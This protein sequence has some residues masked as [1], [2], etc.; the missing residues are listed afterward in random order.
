MADKSS[1]QSLVGGLGDF[2]EWVRDTLADEQARRAIVADLGGDVDNTPAAPQ[3]PPAGLQSIKTYRERSDADLEAFFSA[4]RDV[5]G[6]VDVVR[7]FAATLSLGGGATLDETVRALLDLLATNYFRLRWPWVYFLIQVANFAEDTTSVYGDG[8]DRLYGRFKKGLVGLLEAALTPTAT[9]K[10]YQLEEETGPSRLYDVLLHAISLLLIARSIIAE[11]EDL[12]FIY[13]WDVVP[14][15]V[16]PFPSIDASLARMLSVRTQTRSGDTNASTQ[17]TGLLMS[18]GTVPKSQGGPALYFAFGGDYSA[19]VPLS[20]PWS[21]LFETSGASGVGVMF[22]GPGGLQLQSP[23]GAGNFRVGVA[24]EAQPDS[25]SGHSHVISLARG[26][27]LQ[28]GR[29]RLEATLDAKAGVLQASLRDSALLL[30]ADKL[31]GF[32][33]RLLPPGGLRVPFDL[34]AGLSSVRGAFIEGEV[35]LLGKLDSQTRSTPARPLAARSA[36]RAGAPPQ[37]P[38]QQPP[39]PSPLPPAL[40]PLPNPAPDA[41]GLR[42]RIPIGRSIG[43]VTV[44]ELNF[45]LLRDGPSEDRRHTAEVTTSLSVKI[46]PVMARVEHIGLQLA[47]GTPEDPSKANSGLLDL[48][49][50]LRT[51]DGVAIAIDAKGVVSGG[52]FL[53]HDRVQGLYAGVLQ[54]SLKERLTLTAFGLLATRLPDGS[55][56]YSLLV[57]ITAEGF[58]PLP[59]GLGF[60]LSAIGGMLGIHRRFDEVAMREGLKSGALGKLLFPRDVV[61]NAAEIIRNLATLFPAQQGTHLV[62]LLARIAWPT[63]MLVLMELALIYEINGRGRLIVLGRISSLLPSQSND[64]VRLNLDALGLLDFNQGTLE[65]DAQLVDSRLAHQFVLT[66]AM[67]LRMRFGAGPGAGFAMAVGGFNPRFSPPLPMPPLDRVTIALTTG[68]NP[69][70]TCEA[71]IAITP[72]TVQFGARASLYAAAYGFSVEGDIGF[73]VLIQLL[74]FHFLADFHA[75]IQLKHGTHNLFKVSVKG[76]LEGPLPLRV[77]ARATFEILWCDFSIRFD[78]TLVGGARPPLP[79]AIDAFAELKRALASEDSWTAQPGPGRVH[80]VTLR[81]VSGPGLALDPLGDLTLRQTVTPLNTTRKLDLFGG[82]PLAGERSFRINEVRLNTKLQTLDPLKDLFAPAQ[83]FEMSDDEK[84]SSPS[85]AEMESGVR[86]GSNAVLFEDG[87]RVDSPLV[88]KTFVIDPDAGTLT[89][90]APYPLRGGRLGEQARFGAVARGGLRRG[91]EAR[92]RNDA[93]TPAVALQPLRL[94]VASVDELIV[95]PPDAALGES[96]IEVQAALRSLNRQGSA[97]AWQLVPAHELAL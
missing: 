85:F 56:G 34:A 67:A 53:F 46:G 75:S 62:G 84:L 17:A 27:E 35:P 57:F 59:L 55:K 86:M 24:V 52:G 74:P 29:L 45:E 11:T 89:P 10:R 73:D 94:L 20:G 66:G 97:A 21:F 95:K 6:L 79:P 87:Q 7:G 77:S 71:Y 44:H 47:I 28:L 22:G 64:L 88:F 12:D 1:L 25:L 18:A 5:R 70:L 49:F 30:S 50:G 82:A 60:T 31:D 90:H 92:F 91:G 14:G 33:A 61:R 15:T 93:L 37:L 72:N 38:P 41:P 80:G 9:W 8:G 69:R 16:N 32:L 51:P 2:L 13:G 26:T 43:P 42:V 78:K 39:Q 63:P 36:V 96:W 65:V 81:K 58:R 40:P 23:S 54:L 83:Y 19:A 3:F 48:D 4:L 68:A 76:E